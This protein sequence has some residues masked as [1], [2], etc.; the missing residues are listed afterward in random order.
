M[1]QSASK[2]AKMVSA[3]VSKRQRTKEEKAEEK[4]DEKLGRLATVISTTD[5]VRVGFPN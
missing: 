2:A 3:E 5:G 4:A 1:Y